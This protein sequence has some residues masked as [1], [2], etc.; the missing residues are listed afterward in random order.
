MNSDISRLPVYCLVI[1]AFALEGCASQ[2]PD[3]I[4]NGF[5]TNVTGKSYPFT[6]PEHE[7]IIYKNLP[8]QGLPCKDYNTI[9]QVIVDTFEPYVGLGRSPD[10]LHDLLK[11]GGASVGA[12]AVINVELVGQ[13]LVGYDIKC[14]G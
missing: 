7:I 2:N 10:T 1:A 14:K 9:G 11:N 12:D 4:K 13:S 8:N 5:T 6:Q 3:N